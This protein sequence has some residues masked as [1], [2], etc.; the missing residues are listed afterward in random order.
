MNR[1]MIPASIAALIFT[2]LP[3][4]GSTI[5][6]MFLTDQSSVVQ[7][8]GFAGIHV[9]HTVT[10]QFRLKVGLASGTARFDWVDATLSPSP[11]LYTRS[12]GLLFNM[13]SL[14]ATSVEPGRIVFEGET[15]DG[16]AGQIDLVLTISGD[17]AHLIGQIKSPCCDLFDYDLEAVAVEVPPG[18]TY[19]YFDDF[20]TDKTQDDSYTHSVFWPKDAFPPP[21]PYLFYC[22][23]QTDRQLGFMDHLGQ[24]AHLGYSFPIAPPPAP[25]TVTGILK[26]T[27]RFPSS[28]F[29]SQSP[30]GYL[31][32]SLSSD[33]H[34]WTT[35]Q[36][37]QPGRNEI[38]LK[39]ATGTCYVILLGT[40]VLVDD[41]AVHLSS[42]ATTIR[43]PDDFPTIQQAIDAAKD[44]DV[45][46][47]APGTYRGPGNRDIQFRGRAI[48]LQSTDGPERTI[49]DCSDT[50]GSPAIPHRGFYF[51][52][53]E[54]ADSV[55]RGFT[56]I[57]GS[58]PGSQ[59]PPDQMRWNLSPDHPVGAGIYCEYSSPTIVNCVIRQCATEIGGGIGCVGGNPVIIGCIVE[60]CTAGGFGPA[61]SGGR[62]GAVG[63]IRGADVKILDCVLRRNTLYHNGFGAGIYIRRAAA[64]LI[65]SELSSNGPRTENGFMLGGGFYTADPLTSLILKNCIISNNLA[66]AGSAGLARR[67]P[68]IADCTEAECPRNRVRI[69]NCT[70][71]H[72]RLVPGPWA[73]PMADAA[74]QSNGSDIKIRNSIIWYNEGLQISLNDPPA[75]P[76]TFSDVQGGYPGTGNIADQPLF[77]PSAVPDYHLQSIYGRYD[78]HAGAWVIDPRH[79]PCIDAGDPDDP[80]ANEPPPNGAR[81]NMGAYGGTRQASKG[82]SRLVYHVDKATG[83]D[84]NTGLTRENAF[85]TI[86]KGIDAAQDGDIVLVWPGVYTEDVTFD[87]K[88]ITVQSAADAAVVT[89]KSDWAFSFFAG[90]QADSVLR[91][92]VITGSP[93]GIYCDNGARPTITNLTIAGNGYGVGA[94]F[95]A[96]PNI[97]NCILWNNSIDDLSEDLPAR[98]SC[99]QRLAGHEGPGNIS[100]D[101]LFA[102]PN[103]GDYHL[104]SRFGRYWPEHNL[105]VIDEVTS[106][107]I[108]AGQP[109][110][111]PDRERIPHGG[112]LNMGAYGGTPFA[113]MSSWP[114][115]GDVNQDGVVNVRDFVLLADQ[116]LEFMPWLPR[117]FGGGEIVMPIDGAI[118]PVPKRNRKAL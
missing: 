31:L 117:R 6:Y 10:G 56:I 2:V 4:S 49:I 45:I 80:V 104:R 34:N 36:H 61:E 13:T 86:Q 29:F 65:N 52:E 78:P 93:Y 26:L 103:N 60:D 92:F 16:T 87:A 76:V 90:E 11:F 84:T 69:I 44:G 102:D 50:S 64:L 107:C 79:S 48:T 3:A 40:K 20:T 81:I 25:R 114:L 111:Y 14:K 68:D 59:I 88:A 15:A 94:W 73:K 70:I 116:W 99:I 39:S 23:S 57:N 113:S 12:L 71:A 5:D 91:N 85:A 105:W 18:W 22:A 33:A 75:E 63:V 1:T 43:V 46:E 19:Q 108:D 82:R 37:L 110:L 115:L 21:E 83:S 51:H 118:I 74:I 55:L 38:P 72:N 106:P 100:Q 97:S 53:G 47:V 101:P 77:A 17:S 109:D 30:P 98:F 67:G 24:P 62:G 28:A 54:T 89:A 42:P 66:A 112:R 95:G 32:Y 7:T 27:V 58:I 9:T 96:E 41:L 8:G 35:P